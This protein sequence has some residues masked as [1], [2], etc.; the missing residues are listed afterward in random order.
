MLNAIGVPELI[1]E[2]EEEY[3][4]LAENLAINKNKLKE[5]KKILLKNQSEFPLFNTELF[6]KHIEATYTQAYQLF[7]EKKSPA[8]IYVK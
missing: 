1:T 7:L 2:S 3:E 4:I 6:T 8:T 5:I